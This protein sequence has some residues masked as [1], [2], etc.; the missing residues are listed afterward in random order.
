M[1]VC[2]QL[3]T[4]RQGR[5][6]VINLTVSKPVIVGRNP[7]SCSYLIDDTLVSAIHCKIYAV[8]SPSG[9]VIISCQDVSRNGITLNGQQIRK[10]AVIVMDGDVIQLP[11]SLS[12]TCFHL[13]KE[14]AERLSFFDPTPPLQ[15]R[16]KRVGKYIV[17]SQ[18][19]GTG[20]F[21]TVH[22]ALDPEKDRQVA[23]KSIRTKKDSEVG[24]VV[25]EVRILITLKHPNINEIYDTE[26]N[27]KFI[28]IFL[29]LC[30][31][32]D[33][34]TYITQATGTGVRI[35]EA[36]A[37]YIMY[38]LLLALNYLHEKMISHRDLKASFP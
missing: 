35:C 34:F 17:T 1:D 2:A 31:G 37:K 28:H 18:C 21:A 6:E 33:L 26:E 38:Q 30:T 22:L 15:P 20:S 12:F 25:K 32:G 29:Q 24:Q 16:Q 23:C 27:K 11:N 14:C 5:K 8:R 13:W 36:E 7:D 3:V 4:T 10:T 9:G 19:L